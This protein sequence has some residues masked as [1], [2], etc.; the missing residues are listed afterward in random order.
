VYIRTLTV[1]ENHGDH[2]L[3]TRLRG[4]A[5]GDLVAMEAH[6]HKKCSLYYNPRNIAQ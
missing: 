1:A 4:V 6:Y 3:L 5:N 2:E